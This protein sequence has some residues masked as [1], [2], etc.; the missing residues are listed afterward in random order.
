MSQGPPPILGAGFVS[1]TWTGAML[2][3]G[4]GMVAFA[5]IMGAFCGLILGLVTA[6]VSRFLSVT[7]G[8]NF[9]SVGWTLIC[10]A[11]GAIAFG[12]MSVRDSD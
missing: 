1:N 11:L 3:D 10:V 5:V 8:R 9:G 2:E 7:V 12:I 4:P 6:Q